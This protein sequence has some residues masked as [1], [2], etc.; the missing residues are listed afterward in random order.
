M[1]SEDKECGQ[2]IKKHNKPEETYLRS[3]Q[4]RRY[5]GK[6]KSLAS[7]KVALKYNVCAC[8]CARARDKP[9]YLNLHVYAAQVK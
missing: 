5:R 2:K 9:C 4:R 1:S 8:V 6:S 3:P 7:C